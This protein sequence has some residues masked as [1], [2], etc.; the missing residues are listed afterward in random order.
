MLGFEVQDMYAR[1]IGKQRL[2]NRTFWLPGIFHRADPSI[3]LVHR[4]GVPLLLTDRG[5]GSL[6]VLEGV[7]TTV[8]SV[9]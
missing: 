1:Q 5:H 4:R 8:P 2:K 3:F 7:I 9:G 6:M